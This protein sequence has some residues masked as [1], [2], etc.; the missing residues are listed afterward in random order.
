MGIFRNVGNAIADMTARRRGRNE[1]EQATAP[2]VARRPA[3]LTFERSAMVH[4]RPAAP[5]SLS[6][7][8]TPR[9]VPAT[10]SSQGQMTFP[11]AWSP[12]DKLLMRAAQA[13]TITDHDTLGVVET[14]EIDEAAREER[15]MYMREAE[16]MGE[17]VISH[18][19]GAAKLPAVNIKARYQAQ[20]DE[21]KAMAELG[22]SLDTVLVYLKIAR[23]GLEPLF[24]IT[25]KVDFP[26]FPALLF[27]PDCASAFFANRGQS[28][29]RMRR[30]FDRLCMAGADVRCAEHGHSHPGRRPEAIV[31]LHLRAYQHWL[32]ADL[33][34]ARDIGRGRVA[35]LIAIE[36][37]R[38]DAHA[39]RLEDRVRMRLEKRAKYMLSCLEVKGEHGEVVAYREDPPTLYG[40]VVV[41]SVVGVVALEPLS[42]SRG[43][44]TVGFFH[45]NRP[46]EE[47]WNCISLAILMN[48]V[49]INIAKVKAAMERIPA[50]ERPA[51]MP[52]PMHSNDVF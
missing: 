4:I 10:P 19:F 46:E 1:A 27:T 16:Q 26:K 15:E 22:W 8:D 42:A 17:D 6:P 38:G 23:R 31:R 20:L 14:I 40:F 21:A 35:N 24:P 48:W 34:L 50:D 9:P 12:V 29:F 32:W 11:A 45:L 41:R 2:L 5:Q 37:A 18:D 33:D 52:G 3:E 39:G 43:M 49:A 7:P 51:P 44:K 28:E 13:V 36:A 25:W 30:A 47:V